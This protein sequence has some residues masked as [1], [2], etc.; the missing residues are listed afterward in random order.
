M[1]S[2]HRDTKMA[3]VIHTNHLLLPVINR[4]GIH[5]GFHDKLI[6]DICSDLEID[7]EF[8]LEILNTFHN[9]KYF[10]KGKLLTFPLS[11]I[12]EYLRKTHIYYISYIIPQME[13]RLERMK[14]VDSSEHLSLLTSF[15]SKYKK[16]IKAHIREEEELVF[17]YVLELE[18]LEKNIIKKEDFIHDYK[19]FSIHTFHMEHSDVDD[20]LLDLK[21]LI[22]KYTPPN[23]N[24]NACI[25]FINSLFHFEQDLKNHARIED[26]I[27]YPK[28]DELN[29]KLLNA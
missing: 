9:E 5:L 16:E 11:S 26:K 7:I 19:D 2:F 8:F 29:K 22:I 14:T 6:A 1:I 18:K 15:Y 17:P 27:L 24:I 4:F 21:N 23:Y 20:K 3:D 13:E 10:P 25:A 28:V 12:I